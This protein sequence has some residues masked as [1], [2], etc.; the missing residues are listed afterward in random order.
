MTFPLDL[1][2]TPLG[3]QHGAHLSLLLTVYYMTNYSADGAPLI[4]IVP[5]TLRPMIL[6]AMHDDITSG[7]LGFAWTLH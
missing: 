5:Q 7:L 4:F 6:Q 2:L 3:H 1:F